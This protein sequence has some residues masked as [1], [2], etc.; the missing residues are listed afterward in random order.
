MRSLLRHQL[1]TC[2][3][4]KWFKIALVVACIFAVGS[5]IESWLAVQKIIEQ[6]AEAG[7]SWGTGQ[8]IYDGYTN[9]GCYANWML[10]NSNSSFCGNLFFYLAP[11]L[12]SIPFSWSY[13]SGALSGYILQLYSQGKR[14][15]VL[16]AK[17]LTT[18]VAGFLVAVVPLLLNFA[19]IVCLLPAYFPR[20]E[21]SSLVG[22]FF[23]SLF[24]WLFYN[25]PLGYV[26]AYTLLD[27]ALAGLWAVLVLAISVLVKNRTAV[28]VFPYVG[29][30]LWQYANSAVFD[31][32]GVCGF[33]VN[34]ID[35]MSGIAL[36]NLSDWRSISVQ[37]IVMAL[38]SLTLLSIAKRGDVL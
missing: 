10:V 4:G 23:N 33:N 26:A 35:D 7:G 24:A 22:I 32:L 13:R 29:L 30:L 1:I 20:Y 14:V 25:C 11:L 12:A 31:L 21:D 6:T 18:F 3:R 17:G 15:H 16:A 9:V 19:I 2:L 37:M 34:I 38:G 36:G 28:M 5:A 27:G 8:A